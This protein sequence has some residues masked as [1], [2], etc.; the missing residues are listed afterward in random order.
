[1]AMLAMFNSFLCVYQR[2]NHDKPP[3]SYGFLMVF[4]LIHHFPMVFLWFSHWF[5]IFLLIHLWFPRE[6]PKVV[7]E[8]ARLHDAKLSLES[9][10]GVPR[11]KYS[12]STCD[13][14]S[15][16]TSEYVT[17][18]LWYMLHVIYIYIHVFIYIH[19][20]IYI[21]IYLYIY[22]Y[23]CIYLYIYIYV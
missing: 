11:R 22:T 4:P 7:R 21:R 8:I 16:N 20:Y 13:I 12:G 18:Q 2:I 3:F 23:I 1:M 19:I 5:T 10:K 6:W 17:I 15:Y 14:D 9:T